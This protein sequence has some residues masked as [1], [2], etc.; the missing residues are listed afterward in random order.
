MIGDFEARVDDELTIIS[1]QETDSKQEGLFH[2]YTDEVIPTDD[3][4][5]LHFLYACNNFD[6]GDIEALQKTDVYINIMKWLKRKSPRQA[7][8]QI[9]E[10]ANKAPLS[11]KNQ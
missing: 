6:I 1:Y 4:I 5:R 9:R 8:N 2:I 11:F 3:E 10:E 7:L